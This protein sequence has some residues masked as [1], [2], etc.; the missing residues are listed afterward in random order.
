VCGGRGPGVWGGGP[1][2]FA[3]LEE[4]LWVFLCTDAGEWWYSYPIKSEKFVQKQGIHSMNIQKT[5]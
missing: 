4:A 3:Y 5:Q 1:N 2:L